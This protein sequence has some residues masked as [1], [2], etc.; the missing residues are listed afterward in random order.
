MRRILIRIGIGLVV[1]VAVAI[2]VLDVFGQNIRALFSAGNQGSLA[3]DTNV[4]S[5]TISGN[6]PQYSSSKTRR[7]LGHCESDGR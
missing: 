4:V 2:G 6:A 3:G 7:I 5:R 1:F